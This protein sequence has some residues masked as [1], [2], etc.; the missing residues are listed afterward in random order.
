MAAASQDNIHFPPRLIL[1]GALLIGMLLALAVHMIGQQ[2]GLNLGGLWR[3][4]SGGATAA[5]IAWWI[6]S[7][8]GFVGGYLTA[9]LMNSAASGQLPAALRNF[10]IVVLVIFLTAAGQAAAVPS[11][12]PSVAGLITGLMALVAGG[13]MA[14]CGAYFALRRSDTR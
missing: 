3:S 12:A 7:S 4:D 6:M 9:S 1:G 11:G 8:M 13:V 14:F 5:A 10:L 2:F